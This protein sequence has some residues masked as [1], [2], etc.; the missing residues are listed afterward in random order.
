MFLHFIVTGKFKLLEILGTFKMAEHSYP[1]F[2]H[3]K[4]IRFCC[5]TLF[6]LPDPRAS[7]YVQSLLKFPTVWDAQG[8]SKSPPHPVSPPLGHN[9]DSC[10]TT[11]TETPKGRGYLTH[12]WA[13]YRGAPEGLK[14]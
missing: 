2:L 6:K 13:P 7:I 4:P 3:S 10:I 9:I 12:V 8:R 1:S 14:S 5:L 11:V